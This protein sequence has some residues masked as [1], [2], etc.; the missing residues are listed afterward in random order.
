MRIQGRQQTVISGGSVSTTKH[1]VA[2]ESI[3]PVEVE[4]LQICDLIRIHIV[5]RHRILISEIR[6]MLHLIVVLLKDISITLLSP[7]LAD[8]SD[9]PNDQTEKDSADYQHIHRNEEDSHGPLIII[10]P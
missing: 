6:L 3:V 2:A 7:S 4:I 5:H 8:T 10:I 9:N 1:A